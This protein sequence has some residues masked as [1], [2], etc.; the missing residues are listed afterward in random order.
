[1]ARHHADGHVQQIFSLVLNT[2]AFLLLEKHGTRFQFGGTPDVGCRD[3]L[4]TLKVLINSCWNHDLS[5][6]VGFIDLVKAYNTAN[7]T[8][9]LCILEQYGAPPKFVASIETIYRDNIA[10]LK[11]EKEVVEVP[12]TVGVQQGDNMAPVLFLFLMTVFTET[13]K[14]VWKQQ[15][16][17][18]LNV[19]T[20]ADDKLSKGRICSHTPAMFSSKSLN[21]YEILQCLYVDDIGIP[22]GMRNDLL[23]GME[24]IFHHFARFGLEMHIG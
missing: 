9:P 3:G 16:I 14:I 18:I 21:A 13:L 22:F 7:H 23:Q 20:T 5:S 15:G 11:I 2:C 17:L 19:V 4:F 10:V 12:Q 1:M 6:Y 24:P 8:L